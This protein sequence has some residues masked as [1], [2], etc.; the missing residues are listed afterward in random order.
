MATVIYI[1][2]LGQLTNDESVEEY[3][4]RYIKD[5]EDNTPNG[6]YYTKI[7]KVY[8]NKNQSSLVV[9]IYQHANETSKLKEDKLVATFYDF[10]YKEHL[11]HKFQNYS[12]FI[13]NSLVL[14]LV[15]KKLPSLLSSLFKKSTY[16]KGG[17]TFYMF[18]LFFIMALAVV[19]LIPS[20]TLVFD[21][22]NF[23]NQMYVAF[24]ENYADLIKIS[25][26]VTILLIL[27]VPQSNTILNKV[28]AEF[29]TIDNYT[30]YSKQRKAIQENLD[31]LMKYILEKEEDS[32]IH[33]HTY[34]FGSIIA[35]DA[36][37]PIGN[38]PCANIQNNVKQLITIGAPYEFI[39][40][41]YP[42]FYNDRIDKM[43]KKIQWINVYS[44]LDAFA[45]NFR[46][47]NKSGKAH[48]GIMD[49]KVG[50]LNLNYETNRNE[51]FNVFSFIT[52]KQIN[53]HKS[54]W[55]DSNSGQSCTRLILNKIKE[56]EYLNV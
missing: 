9:R 14:L 7:E 27:F 3:A 53:R 24:K 50:P 40:N 10:K 16:T 46:E 6:N 56:L 42:N 29:T 38:A 51:K 33:L 47:D 54:Y 30:Q 5:L 28:A 4:V 45:S 48:Y 22:F 12:L 2:G 49:K 37:F 36:L 21:I 39:N 25:M 35:L 23:N 32:V 55:V 43:T 19:L 26:S 20:F 8:Y 18:I 41:F 44:T 15:I 11:N 34:S 13:Q 31:I 1:A 17:Q 52:L